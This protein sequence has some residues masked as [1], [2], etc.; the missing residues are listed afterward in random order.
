MSN[1]GP[2]TTA[3]E[4]CH[5]FKSQIKDRTFL[6]TGTSAKGLGAKCATSI[7]HHSPAHIILVS[8]SKSKVDP[9]LDEIRKIDP[10]VSAQ[11]VSC[12][13]SDQD[14][15]RQAAEAILKDATISKIDVV[16]NN[17]GVMAIMDY[18]LDKHGNELTLS[19]N[20][21]GHFLLTNLLMP[22]ILAA[23]KGARIVNLSSYG[24]RT[25][26]FRFHDPNYDGGKAYNP[27]TAYGQSKTANILFSVELARRLKD[28]GIHSFSVHPG[29]IMTT[30][31]ANHI[32]FEKELPGLMETAQKEN[33]DVEFKLEEIK[34]V[35]QGSSSSL[36]AALDPSLEA[37]SGG[38]IQ[39][40]QITDA[41]E[42]AVNPENA[43]KLWLY[44][45][46]VV[47]QKFDLRDR[48]AHH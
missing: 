16:I 6:I 7:A 31:L 38:Y 27:W 2:K 12:E 10:K 26:V 15:V 45:E 20:H 36:W 34:D 30:G 13:L 28:H 37:Q 48:S 1:F 5:A 22:K 39:D 41:M 35:S 32:D 9:V 29:V 24:H 47:G 4:V 11:F 33:P 18:T 8:R 25:G 21:I 42:Y 23:G 44:S 46:E 19:S 17:A 43:K 14:S 40:C 3:E